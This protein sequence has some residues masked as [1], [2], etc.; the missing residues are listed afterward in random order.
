MRKML[1]I[2]IVLLNI[3]S[4][5]GFTRVKQSAPN[6]TILDRENKATAHITDGDGVRV[7]ITLSQPVSQQENIIFTLGETSLPA[8]SCVVTNGDTTCTTDLFAS[9]GWY[10]DAN[11]TMQ[12]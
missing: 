12:N 4:V 5:E 9:L 10:W 8:G 2:A 6:I 1:L 3:L 7:Q 11:G